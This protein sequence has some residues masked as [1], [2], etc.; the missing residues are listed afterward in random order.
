[1]DCK[2]CNACC[3]YI[4]VPFP[5]NSREAKQFHLI[6]GA[7]LVENGWAAYPFTC[8][9]LLSGAKLCAIYDKRPLSCRVFKQNGPLCKLCMKAK[10]VKND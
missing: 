6:R 4:L 8:P 10:G 7:V 2:E 1:M 3:E 5:A 9:Y